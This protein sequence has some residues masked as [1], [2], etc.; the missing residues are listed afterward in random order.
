MYH[1]AD[2]KLLAMK[3]L[4]SEY[5]ER[6]DGSM[7]RLICV[8]INITEYYE[9]A[10]KMINRNIDLVRY[11]KF[12]SDLII[13]ELCDSIIASLTAVQLPQGTS[14][15]HG[16]DKT[17]EEQLSTSGPAIQVL[18]ENLREYVLA[19]GDDITQNG[20]KLYSAF[21]KIR[22][23]ICVVKNNRSASFY[24]RLN[25]ESIDLEDGFTRD[26]RSIGRE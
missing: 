19:L 22:N 23:I 20:L 7:P 25:P 3:N 5:S 21:K 12:S 26:V 17:V 4:G 11:K 6:L 24:L 18:Y 13:S 15:K 8:A 9:Y 1:K 16:S 10:V 14:G 2:F